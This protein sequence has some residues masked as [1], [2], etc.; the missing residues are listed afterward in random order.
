MRRSTVSW[1]RETENRYTAVMGHLKALVTSDFEHE[2]FVSVE[3]RSAAEDR[4]R[5]LVS[6]ANIKRCSLDG[7]LRVAEAMMGAIKGA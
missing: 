5:V 3:I 1:Q 6:R 4:D 7:G 2:Q